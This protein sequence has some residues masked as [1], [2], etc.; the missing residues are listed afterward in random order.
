MSII[1]KP[2]RKFVIQQ[3][4]V[5]SPEEV[6]EMSLLFIDTICTPDVVYASS[7]KIYKLFEDENPRIIV[8]HATTAYDS[9]PSN[10]AEWNDVANS[11]LHRIVSH[12]KILLYTDMVRW[13]VDHVDITAITFT[14]MKNTILGLLKLRI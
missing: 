4:L 10:N 11:F 6:C 8:K 13:V 12:P 7:E 14:T 2:R 9:P 5:W 3:E 1:I